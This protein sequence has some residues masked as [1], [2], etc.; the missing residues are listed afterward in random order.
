MNR[1]S[2]EF[3]NLVS[4]VT[5]GDMFVGPNVYTAGDNRWINTKIVSRVEPISTRFGKRDRIVHVDIMS[6]NGTIVE[7]DRTLWCSQLDTI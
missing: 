2:E 5:V 7:K 4:N 3:M 1:E 6:S